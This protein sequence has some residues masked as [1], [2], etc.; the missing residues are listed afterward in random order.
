M[1]EEMKTFWRLDGQWVSDKVLADQE[2][3]TN[4]FYA[5]ESTHFPQSVVDC[6][7]FLWR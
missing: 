1:E 7:R 5:T 2:N 3:G 4:L 6:T